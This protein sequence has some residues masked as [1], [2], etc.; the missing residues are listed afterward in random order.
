MRTIGSV[1]LVLAVAA[2]AI[3][4]CARRRG[5]LRPTDGTD[6][7][8]RM[9]RYGA[10]LIGDVHVIIAALDSDGVV[11]WVS[12][13]VRSFIG[14]EPDEVVGRTIFDFVPPADVDDFVHQFQSVMRGQGEALRTVQRILDVSGKQHIVEVIGRDLRHDSRVGA[15]VLGV[16]DVTAERRIVDAVVESRTRFEEACEIAGLGWWQWDALTHE[17]LCSKDLLRLVGW[18][19]QPSVKW[20][21][22]RRMLVF[23]DDI[24]KLE[25]AL[26]PVRISGQSVRAEHRVIHA[27]GSARHWIVRARAFRDSQGQITRIAGTVEDATEV[28][29]EEAVQL[30]TQK[31]EALDILAG[32]I[33]HDFNNLLAVILGN[34]SLARELLGESPDEARA[35]LADAEEASRRAGRLANQLQSYSREG[36]PEAFQPTDLGRMLSDT[37]PFLLHGTRVRADIRVAEDLWAVQG[38]GAALG[39]VIQNLVL[40]AVAAMPEG[41]SLEVLAENVRIAEKTASHPLAA[42]FY[43]RMTVRDSGDGIFPEHLPRIFDPYFTTRPGGHGLGLANTYRIVQRHLGHIGVEST[44]GAGSVFEVLLPALSPELRPSHRA[45]LDQSP[46]DLPY[47]THVL[48]VDDEEPVGAAA[49]RM[50][51]ALRCEVSVA[52][53]SREALLLLR[54]ALEQGRP[55]QV[56]LA[57]LTMPGDLSGVDLVKQLWAVDPM[58]RAVLTSGYSHDVS[59]LRYRLHGFRAVLRKPYSI[60]ELKAAM[61]SALAAHAPPIAD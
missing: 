38:D 11:R 48:V 9:G 5:T 28:R 45:T 49:A 50:L 30:R 21:D 51:V 13:N 33:A 41:G 18:P 36:L 1:L 52:P 54:S 39:Q 26:E 60:D 43:V 34:V 58:L 20:S 57:D 8:G 7:Y 31:F 15:V 19:S 4:L 40:N 6:P 35:A 22:L 2:L 17:V 27:D 23:P 44:R 37:V 42:G 29:L 14:A 61:V 16:R 25:Q 32:G 3:A 46:D 12:P 59:M 56:A 24:D 55:Y 53:G 10:A 47:G